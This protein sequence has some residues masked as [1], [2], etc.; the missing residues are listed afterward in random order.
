MSFTVSS[1][2]SLSS[3]PLHRLRTFS[4]G[5]INNDGVDH[6]HYDDDD[7]YQAVH[8]FISSFLETREGPKAMHGFTFYDDLVILF[9]FVLQSIRIESAR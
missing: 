6:Y 9:H 3:L 4:K 2:S 7:Y 1:H 5:I 8:S